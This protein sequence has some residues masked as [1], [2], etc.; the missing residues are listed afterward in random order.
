MATKLR[1]PKSERVA[2]AAKTIEPTKMAIIISGRVIPER[3]R[4]DLIWRVRHFMLPGKGSV[5]VNVILDPVL[6]NVGRHRTPSDDA[7]AGPI[8]R[9]RDH[10]HAVAVSR[11]GRKN[12]IGYYHLACVG[13]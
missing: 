3:L 13:Q 2:T 12:G 5:V 9:H 7:S 11:G 4:W 6:G 8:Q 1:A 10:F